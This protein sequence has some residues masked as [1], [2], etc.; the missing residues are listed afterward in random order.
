MNHNAGACIPDCT[1]IPAQTRTFIDNQYVVPFRCQV[2][3]HNCP[4][5]AGADDT[6]S[7]LTIPFAFPT[8]PTKGKDTI[9]P[10]RLNLDKT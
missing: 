10:F 2:A 4:A 7:H 9:K 8:L 1:T 5:E 3:S 6:K